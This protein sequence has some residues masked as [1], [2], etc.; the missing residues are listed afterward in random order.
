MTAM[1]L[2]PAD[3]RA[4]MARHDVRPSRA[5]GQNFLVDPNTARRIVRLAGLEPGARVL[6]IGPGI[7]SLTV[8]LAHAGFRVLALELDRHLLPVLEEVVGGV[9]DVRVVAGDAM[10]ADLPALLDGGDW[11][12]VSNLP[13]NVA[14]PLVVRI[15]EE[16]PQ[17]RR[18]LVMIQREVGERLAAGPGEA[19][20][21]AVSVKV[22]YFGA[23]SVVGVVPPTVFVP[24]PKVESALVR[25]DR[26]D[27]PPVSVP[28]PSE[29]FALVQAGFGQRRKMLRGALRGVL[30]AGAS[31]VL[32]AAGIAPE[33]RAESLSL[34]QWAEL[35]RVVAARR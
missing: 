2:S 27:A 25:I 9:G 4:L 21:G 7:G 11:S 12:L 6:E 19:A 10:T 8:E 20:Y 18:L 31:D 29:L 32:Q 16:A 26:H 30:G 22:A 33:A 3:A 1:S 13:Y 5:L 17:V 24:R 23:A 15:L 34:E 14:T 28:E 35:A